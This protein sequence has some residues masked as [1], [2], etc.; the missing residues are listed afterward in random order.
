MKILV[1]Q[2]ALQRRV[3]ELAAQ[4]A[5][6]YAGRE[7]DVICLLNG[8]SVFCAD[9][10]R[11]IGGGV[12]RV[13][14][15]G[16]D[17]YAGAR[18]SGEVRLTLDVAEP[19]EGRHVLVVEGVVISGRTPKYLLDMLRLRLPASLAL[20]ALG[21]KPRA[22]AVELDVAYHGFEFGAEM[23]AGYGMGKGAQRALPYIVA[24]E[25]H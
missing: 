11:A 17:S 22:R 7:L 9:L 10:V 14:N 24:A 13:H 19:L 12:T 1:E 4:I 25:A 5:R 15:L 2:A 16:F 8:A 6:D 23:A 21:V 18:A 20:C 3:A